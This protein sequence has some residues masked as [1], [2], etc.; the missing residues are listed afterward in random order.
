MTGVV[1]VRLLSRGAIG[2]DRDAKFDAAGTVGHFVGG[3]WSNM[4]VYIIGQ[5]KAKST[6]AARLLRSELGL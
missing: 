6:I 2:S 1:A 4:V 3:V 5:R